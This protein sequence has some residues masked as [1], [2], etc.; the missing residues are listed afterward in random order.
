MD[1][2]EHG[3][4]ESGVEFAGFKREMVANRSGSAKP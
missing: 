3:A 1:A 2:A 4:G